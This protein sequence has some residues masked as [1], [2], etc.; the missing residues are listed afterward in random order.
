MRNKHYFDFFTRS[1]P[2]GRS[3]AKLCYK[4]FQNNPSFRGRITK[5]YTLFGR[6][7]LEQSLKSDD[8]SLVSLFVFALC[9]FFSTL[10]FQILGRL[11]FHSL[12]SMSF[13]R[14]DHQSLSDTSSRHEITYQ[15]CGWLN[16]ANLPEQIKILRYRNSGLI[17]CKYTY[18]KYIDRKVE[19]WKETI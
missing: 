3:F 2:D 6:I 11:L 4:T 16:V 5:K 18:F 7:F 13:C 17:I 1:R 15:K 14:H 9:L 19:L 12:F 10:F 8:T